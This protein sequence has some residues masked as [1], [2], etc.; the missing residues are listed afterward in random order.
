MAS[1]KS[2]EVDSDA[3][4]DEEMTYLR[5]T[6]VPAEVRQA[7]SGV[8]Q[9]KTGVQVRALRKVANRANAESDA[10]LAVR[11]L[12]LVRGDGRALEEALA[13]AAA[14]ERAAGLAAARADQLQTQLTNVIGQGAAVVHSED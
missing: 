6:S 10:L 12:Q 5:S 2:E 8:R 7:L 1:R 4:T 9:E 3:F 11:R 14:A 13:A